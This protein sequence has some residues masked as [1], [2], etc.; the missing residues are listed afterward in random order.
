MASER[1]IGGLRIGKLNATEP[2]GVLHMWWDWLRRF[3]SRLLLF[4][5]DHMGGAAGHR[6]GGRN[7]GLDVARSATSRIRERV[8]NLLV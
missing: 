5:G 2:L 1:F 8:R 7:A 4:R 3:G 6:H